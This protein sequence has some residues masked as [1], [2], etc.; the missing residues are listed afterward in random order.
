VQNLLGTSSRVDPRDAGPTSGAVRLE[1]QADC[2]AG[3]WSNHATTTPTANGQPLI[4]ELTE[5]DINDA[6]DA[7][8]R[9][10]DDYIQSELGGGRVNPDAFT[11]GTS[12]Q[13]QKWFR[14]G[15]QTGDPAGCNTFD[16]NN[17]G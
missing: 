11:H 10:G 5:Q 17:L 4:V 8:A 2:Y 15:Y 7:A 16:T 13:R 14:T 12:A 9:I 3:V 1:L 6:L